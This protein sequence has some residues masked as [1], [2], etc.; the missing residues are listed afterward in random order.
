MSIKF[1][2]TYLENIPNGFIKVVFPNS[3][4]TYIWRPITTIFYG[5]LTSQINV[6]NR[7][8]TII[9]NTK[10][11]DTCT[12]KY[13]DAPSYFSKEP[14]HKVTAVVTDEND[15]VRYLIEGIYVEKVECSLV[16]CPIKISIIEDAK[17]LDLGEKRLLWTR[18][19][20]E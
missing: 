18:N 5:L 6:I 8:T 11:H 12:V 19:I 13:H 15:L 16:T 17:S 9:K 7:G 2:G 14:L 20:V 3:E 10:T 4:N 1:R